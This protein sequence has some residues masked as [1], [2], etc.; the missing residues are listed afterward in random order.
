MKKDFT[1]GA[2]VFKK[3]EGVDKVLLLKKPQ[4]T[5][6]DL[7]KG[8]KE[9]ADVSDKAA[10][11]RE[12]SEESGYKQITITDEKVSVT[13][14]AEKNGEKLEKTVTFYLADYT[15][16]EE[17]PEQHLDNNEDERSIDVKWVLVSKA[18]DLLTFAPFKSALKQAIA[19]QK[20]NS[21]I[22]KK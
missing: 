3:E 8:H 19:K 5:S 15:G 18:A 11:L 2:I 4:F 7:P 1:F 22:K 20:H 10:A 6:W 9:K 13:Y 14:E 17:S 21:E 12:V 16:N